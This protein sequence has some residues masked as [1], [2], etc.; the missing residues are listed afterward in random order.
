MREGIYSG[1]RDRRSQERRRRRFSIVWP[2]RRSGFDRRRSSSGRAGEVALGNL[3]LGLRDRPAVVRILLITVNLLNLTDYAL[4]LNVL[5]SGGG[6]ANPIMRSLFLIDPVYA[7][8]FKI[9]AVFL[10]TVLVWRLRRFRSALEA[11]LVMMVV[12]G[13]VFFYHVIG[14]LV[15]T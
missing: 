14:L 2:E 10:V 1:S 8:L 4:T 12:F 7:G 5:S 3:L 9:A 6:E 11:V 13:A 15:F